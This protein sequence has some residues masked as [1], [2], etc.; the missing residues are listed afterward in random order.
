ME[1]SAFKKPISTDCFNLRRAGRLFRRE[2]RP[3]DVGGTVRLK[4]RGA[5]SYFP[6]PPPGQHRGVPVIIRLR[7]KLS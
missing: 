7:G 5:A 6:D 1:P 2:M 4:E 3:L